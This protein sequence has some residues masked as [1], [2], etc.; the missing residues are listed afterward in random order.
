MPVSSIGH[1]R[2]GGQRGVRPG[3]VRS[4]PRTPACRRGWVRPTA[5]IRRNVRARCAKRAYSTPDRTTNLGRAGSRFVPQRNGGTLVG[6]DSGRAGKIGQKRANPA[7]AARRRNQSESLWFS[8]SSVGIKDLNLAPQ[9]GLEPTTL[10]LTAE[11]STIELL[12]S[13]AGL[14]L[15]FN[16][17]LPLSVKPLEGACSA[18]TPFRPAPSTA[19]NSRA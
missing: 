7:C 8:R 4:R 11:C 15:L 10:R 6:L 16:Q 18:G 13:N 9:V 14:T 12:R 2:G 19:G 1:G 3:T 5:A 17:S